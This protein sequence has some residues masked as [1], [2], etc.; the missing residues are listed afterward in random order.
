MF[1]A[2]GL[3]KRK[4]YLILTEENNHNLNLKINHK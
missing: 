4:Q 1:L 2:K 3:W